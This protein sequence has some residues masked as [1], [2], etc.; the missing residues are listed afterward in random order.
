M[1]SNTLLPCADVSLVI[2]IGR[3]YW[4][5]GEGS[6]LQC[7]Q[8]DDKEVPSEYHWLDDERLTPAS[9]RYARVVAGWLEV[10]GKLR[11]TTKSDSDHV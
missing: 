8:L 7:H 4:L 2:S 6:H 10:L 1:Q 5:D 11:G 3:G 9:H